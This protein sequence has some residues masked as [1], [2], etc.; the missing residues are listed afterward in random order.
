LERSNTIIDKKFMSFKEE[1]DKVMALVGEKIQSGME[2]LSSRFSEALELEGRRYGV[3]ARDVEL[4]K[5]QLETPQENNVL[6]AGLITSLQGRVGELEDVV[7]EESDDDAEGEVVSLSLSDMELVE[8]MVA[9]P[10]PAPLMFCY[11]LV[12]VETPGEFVPPSLH[13]TPSPPYV[14]PVEDDLSH[15]GVLEC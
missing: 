9:L 12:P 6:L 8:N 7:M 15:D 14:K 13:S 4:L 10:V 2:D 3:L 1:L 11:T 5:S